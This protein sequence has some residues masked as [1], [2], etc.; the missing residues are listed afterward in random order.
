MFPSEAEFEQYIEL[1]RER[2]L[3]SSNRSNFRY[4]SSF[5]K[6][7]KFTK[8]NVLLLKKE[9]LETHKRSTVKK[10]IEVIKLIG[11][12]MGVDFTKDLICRT[13]GD[14][15]PMGELITDDEMKQIAQTDLPRFKSRYDPQEINLKYK[16]AFSLLRFYGIPPVDLCNLKWWH[17]KGTHFMIK[18]SKTKKTMTI[19]II[20]EVRKLLDLLPR[21]EHGYIFGSD[22][23]RMKEATLNLELKKRCQYLGMKKN[24]TCYSF[25]HSMI[26]WCYIEGGEGMLPKLSKITGH[27]MN[28]A[29]KHYTQFDVK[30]LSDALYATHPALKQTQSIDTIKRVIINLIHKLIDMSKYEVHLE[31]TPKDDDKRTIH[32]S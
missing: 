29:V 30:A 26:T 23:G 31:I 17:D 21:H 15:Q 1:E 14:V 12:Y 5:F 20:E 9:L 28:T 2:Q 6:N 8:E 16:T 27:D 10:Y 18:R 11:L 3:T 32:L 25:R 22:Q 13:D 19:P 7:R 24:I 4:I